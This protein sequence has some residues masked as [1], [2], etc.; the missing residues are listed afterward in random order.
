MENSTKLMYKIGKIFAII[1][2]VFG[3]LIEF[4]CF[5]GIAEKEKIFQELVNQGYT[6]FSS[7][8]EVAA[9]FIALAIGLIV[10]L[11]LTILLIYFGN[12]ATKAIGNGEMKPQV[13][14][15]VFSILAGQVFYFVGAILGM[16][17]ASKKPTNQQPTQEIQQ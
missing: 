5:Y 13:L 8:E 6:Q 3:V 12:K 16:I 10:A 15:L 11:V 2:I 9:L 17:L 1:E 7:A 14:V 4:V